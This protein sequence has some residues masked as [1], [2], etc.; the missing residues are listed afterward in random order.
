MKP[1]YIPKMFEYENNGFKYNFN[2]MR[3]KSLQIYTSKEKAKNSNNIFEIKQ[4]KENE[5][6]LKKINLNYYNFDYN[7]ELVQ[8]K[9][10]IENNI[11]ELIRTEIENYN[12]SKK[13]NKSGNTNITIEET[14]TEEIASLKSNESSKKKNKILSKSYYNSEKKIDLI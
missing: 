10:N 7:R 14:S 12:F 2:L 3:K 1:P 9:Y 13:N 4:A 11:T 8:L 6:K 5:N